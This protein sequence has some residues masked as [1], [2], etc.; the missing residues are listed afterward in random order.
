M[1][2]PEKQKRSLLAMFTRKDLKHFMMSIVATTLAGW[3]C[4]IAFE[5]EKRAEFMAVR[6]DA[7]ATIAQFAPWNIAQRYA[8]IVF[9]QGNSYAEALAQKQEQQTL[10]FRGFA[11]DLRGSSASTG[12][13]LSSA[14]N[15]CK[16]PERP[17]GIRAFYLSAHVPFPLRFI[18]AF[19]D[20]LLHALV[21]QGLIGF[22]VALTQ[23]VLGALLT[24]LAVTSSRLKL[25]TFFSYALGVPL[26]VLALGS[27]A[28]I[29]LW[30]VALIGLMALKASPLGAFGAQAG[31]T[32]WCVR[33]VAH[34]TAEELSQSAI[35][36]QLKRVVPE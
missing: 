9:T 21:D 2:E 30:L 32:G 36:K 10:L 26:A 31:A 19:F 16:A 14:D 29:P 3:A 23:V 15:P 27:L 5:S 11:C 35:M 1:S 17:Q 22:L 6:Y 18:T 12:F 24:R 8:A 13:S 4:G 33:F 20:L 25:N 28:A 7:Y 34:K